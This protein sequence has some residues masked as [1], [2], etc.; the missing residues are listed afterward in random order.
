MSKTETTIERLR[1]ALLPLAKV[2][3]ALDRG[4]KRKLDDDIGIWTQQS[5]FKESVR[6]TLGQARKAREVYDATEQ[7]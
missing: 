7:N 1:E 3:D 5:N 4:Y 2:A 6:L